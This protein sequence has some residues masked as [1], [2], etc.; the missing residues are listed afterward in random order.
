[1]P[2]E[3]LL[4]SEKTGTILR[5]K[6]GKLGKRG[7]LMENNQANLRLGACFATRLEFEQFT[8]ET[9]LAGWLAGPQAWLDGPEGGMDK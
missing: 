3:L 4:I 6:P 5:K 8:P 2:I 1:M 7:N 9:W